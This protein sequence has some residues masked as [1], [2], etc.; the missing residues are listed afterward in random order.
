VST[1]GIHHWSGHLPIVL[2]ALIAR[3]LA[4]RAARLV[5]T[6]VL[7]L[8]I[9]VI[10]FDPDPDSGGTILTI[11]A[12]EF[13]ANI[14]MFLPVGAVAR[15]WRPSVWRNVLVGLAATVFIESV[16]GLF[17][18]HRVADYRDIIANTSG[19]LLGSL[20]CWAVS[21]ALRRHLPEGTVSRPT[22]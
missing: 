22:S 13:A 8:V 16:Q 15:W 5:C 3:A 7:A 14:V 4:S 21:R 17:L 20:A 1:R 18:P 6:I 9:G 10:V 11:P 12:V 19:A 2:A